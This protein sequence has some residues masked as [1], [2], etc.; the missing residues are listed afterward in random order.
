VNK[1]HGKWLM[2]VLLSQIGYF[3][4]IVFIISSMLVMGLNVTIHD[5]LSPLQDKGLIILSLLANFVVVPLFA[6]VLIYIFPLSSG[7]AAGLILVSIA[8]GA[9]STPK[10]AEFTGGNIAFAVSLTLLM[11]VLTIVLMPFLVPYILEGI[12]M[13]PAKVAFNLVMFMLI[14]I[15]AGIMLRSRVP[16]VAGR[17]LP[18][19]ELISNA[20][21][22][23]IFL[24][25]GILFFAHLKDLFGGP[26]GL[27]VAMIAVLFTVGALLIGYAMGGP[28]RSNRG[29][30]AFGTGFRNITAVL[31]VITASYS[32]LDN[33]VL[34]MVLMVTIFS[35]I[36]VSAIVGLILKKRMDAEKRAGG[37]GS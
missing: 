29:V 23:V 31:V 7:L 26:G 10:V 13:N 21:I 32:S 25:F 18:V 8:A 35:V 30:L 22:G 36:I 5:L 14:P 37:M 20:S 2:A 9:P 11:T 6:F 19:L 24:T 17:M 4:V 12:G 1:F 3:A 28:D 34:L 27:E 15:I 16:G 33:D